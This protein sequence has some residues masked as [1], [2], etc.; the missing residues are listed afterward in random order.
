MHGYISASIG[1]DDTDRLQHSGNELRKALRAARRSLP[2]ASQLANSKTAAKHLIRS[3][4]F[5]R[6]KTIAI[7]LARD[8]ELDPAPLAK[9]GFEH[10][11]KIYLPV[12]RQDGKRALWF[13]AFRPGERMIKNRFGIDEPAAIKQRIP[14]FGLDLIMLPLVGFDLAGNRLGMGGGYYDRTL[15]Y[16]KNRNHWRRPKLIGMAHECQRLI[17]IQIRSWDIPLD[18]IV[19]EAGL[20]M[21]SKKTG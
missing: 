15:A 16:L 8:G 19:S 20:H 10:G 5:L 7:Y 13:V 12:L 11:K 4:L 2:K 6:H 9:A 14:P 3:G 18:G 1:A 17:S 21:I